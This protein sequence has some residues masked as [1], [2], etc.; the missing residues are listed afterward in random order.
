MYDLLL[1]NATL[2]TMKPGKTPYGLTAKGALGVKD[3]RIAYVGRHAALPKGAKASAEHDCGGALVTPALIDCH[4]HLVFAGSRTGEFEARLKGE[5][6]REI[7]KKGGGILSTVKAT[8][9]ATLDELTHFAEQRAK[10]LMAEGVGAIEIK[11]GY[12]LDY[13]T[14]IKILEAATRLRDTLLLRIVRTFLGAHAIPPEYKNDR[15]GYLDLLAHKIGPE[16]QRRNLADAVDGYLEGIAFT[17]KEL[18]NLFRAKQV[19]GTLPVHLHADQ[20]SDGGGAE[21]AASLRALSADHLEYASAAGIRAMA[22]AG[23]VAVLLPGAFY[24]LRET[25]K[26]PVALL[27]KHKVPIAIATDCNPGTSPTLSL[28]LMMSFACTLF[29][30]TPEEALAGVT[31]NAAKALGLG[32]EIGTLEKGKAASAALW[33]LEHPAALSYWVGGNPLEGLILDGRPVI[34]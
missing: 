23:T 31:R 14:E 10:A 20:L 12:G 6:Y 11:S 30:L 18:E 4:T 24:F 22:R 15:Q 17:K 8:R 29:G 26:P 25:R 3:G 9:K 1:T 32:R 34:V 19:F 16:I 5:S 28:R 7:A 2:A 13:K 33:D 27:R 21:F